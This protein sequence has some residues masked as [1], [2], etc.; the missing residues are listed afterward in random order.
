MLATY[1]TAVTIPGWWLWIK[2]AIVF[3]FRVNF[4]INKY[5]LWLAYSLVSLPACENVIFET[6]DSMVTLKPID[7]ERFGLDSTYFNSTTTTLL[8]VAAGLVYMKISYEKNKE[9]LKDSVAK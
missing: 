3:A 6:F 5:L 1:V 8:L 2:V 4:G 9:H 7:M